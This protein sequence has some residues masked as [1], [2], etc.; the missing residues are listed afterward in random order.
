VAGK[1]L[2]LAGEFSRGTATAN[3]LLPLAVALAGRGHEITLALPPPLNA[4]VAASVEIPMRESPVWGLPPPPGL[5]AI[6]YAD[7]L[8]LG[9]YATPGSLNPL[10]DSWSSLLAQTAPDLLITDFAPTAM[11]AARLTGVQQ[12][13]IGD[14]YSLP[15]PDRPMPVLRPWAEVA[16]GTA[17]DA[18]G[19]V[20]AVI[21]ACLMGRKARCATC[22]AACP[23]SSVRFRS[24]ITIRSE[25]M[26]NGMERCFRRR[27]GR[28]GNG[29]KETAS[30]S[31]SI[32]MHVIRRSAR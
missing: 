18:E 8:Q 12:A 11:L 1:R 16:P 7:V 17:A 24:S 22:S 19:R 20:L 32:W 28:M 6:T 9:G 31:I 29:P 3:R 21:D 14:G 2:L 23:A 4:A 13:V 25:R 26:G 15:P 30:V 10:L 5:I 27:R